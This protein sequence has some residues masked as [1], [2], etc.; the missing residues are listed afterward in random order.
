MKRIQRGQ[1]RAPTKVVDLELSQLEASGDTTIPV[2][3]YKCLWCLSRVGGIPAEISFWDV[4][5]EIEVKAK[6][7]GDSRSAVERSRVEQSEVSRGNLSAI[8]LTIAIC[9]RDHHVELRQ[10]LLSLREQTDRDFEVLVVDNAPSSHLTAEVVEEINL[11]RCEY[12][13]EPIGG[14]A[15]ARNTALTHTKTDYVAWIDDDEV[16]DVNWVRSLKEGFAHS[17]DPVSVC[18][19]MLPAEL[20]TEAQIRFEQYGGFNKG[21]GLVPEI[22]SADSPSV[23]SPLYPLPAFGSGGNM[24]FQVRALHSVGDFDRHLGAGTRTHSGEETKA[25][26]MLLRSGKV[27][28]HWP[29]AITWHYH[30]RDMA[31]LQKQL[32]GISAGLPAFYASMIR[33]DPAVVVDMIRLA[34][35]ALRDL[36]IRSGGIRSDQLPLDFP[37]E[38][39]RARRRGLLAGA[40]G[41]AYEVISGDSKPMSRVSR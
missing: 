15:R 39:M 41:Y 13:I 27:V 36:G 4:E 28:L 1:L 14:L 6:D 26:A 7:I 20:E 40:F 5:S 10:A 2:D 21:R 37:K 9:T 22:L 17:S 38:L 35:H 18:G 25:F 32:Y 30:R 8:T 34:P 3:G 12:V 31:A 29:K 33:S 23:I 11:A 16:A 24:A 19:V